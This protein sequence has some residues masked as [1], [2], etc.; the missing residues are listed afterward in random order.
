MANNASKT[1]Q[2]SAYKGYDNIIAV[3]IRKLMEERHTTQQELA[4][5][6]GCSRQAIAQYADGSNAPNI[7]KLVSI[8]K[9]FDVSLDYMVGLSD[10]PTADKDVQFVCEYTGFTQEAIK[11]LQSEKEFIK[12]SEKKEICSE[13]FEI[14]NNYI[15]DGNLLY[16]F[17]YA[18]DYKKYLQQKNNIYDIILH[19]FTEMNE[20]ERLIDEL[21]EIQD[22]ADICL[23]RLQEL[24]TDFVEKM[25]EDTIN[26]L[27]E[28]EKRI[29]NQIEKEIAICRI[30]SKKPFE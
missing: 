24:Q 26:H 12:R 21:G 25:F 29:D 23:F 20:F 5:N 2:A 13:Y 27:N 30:K 1:K 9:Y 16:I 22:K 3:R 8:A 6:T 11:E 10:V 17:T 18:S 4:E 14:I 7:D 28:L 19:Q 15:E